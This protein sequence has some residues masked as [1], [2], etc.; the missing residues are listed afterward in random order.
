MAFHAA[1]LAME[2]GRRITFEDVITGARS[3]LV[4]LGRFEDLGKLDA[5]LPAKPLAQ[6]LKVA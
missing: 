5:I 3:Q 6:P 4:R 2:N 1:V